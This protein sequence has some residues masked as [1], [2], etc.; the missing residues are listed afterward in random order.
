MKRSAFIVFVLLLLAGSVVY[1]NQQKTTNERILAISGTTMGTSYHIKL[2]PQ[3]AKKPNLISLKEKIK[4]RLNDID[5]KMSTYKENSEVSRFN[6]YSGDDWMTIS[7][8]TMSVISTAQEISQLSH[9]A[10]DITVGKLVNLWG[11][12]PTV[13]VDALPDTKTIEILLS[14]VGYYK[15]KLRQMP[16]AIRKSDKRVHLDLSAI[17]KGYAVDAIANLLI[18]N[19]VDNFL[20]EIGGEIIVHGEKYQHQPWIIGIES[21][22]AQ[23]RSIRKKLFLEDV[24]MAT[25]GDYRNYFEENGVRYSHTIDPTTG[26]PI[27]HQLASVTVIDGTCMRADALATAIMVMGPSKGLEFARQQQLAIFMLVKQGDHFME[28][29]SP[30]FKPYLKSEED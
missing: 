10:F 28:K 8:E 19:Q 14:Q 24:A 18:E 17:A 7:P 29:Y 1:L 21:P 20:I 5:G 11:F 22:V 30:A 26:Y 23:Q 12:G 4:I 9:G 3:A 2:A 27:K 6:S 13:R 15:L 25:S 16:P